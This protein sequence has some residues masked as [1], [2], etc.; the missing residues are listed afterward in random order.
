[1][2]RSGWMCNWHFLVLNV[3]E[4]NVVSVVLVVVISMGSDDMI[5]A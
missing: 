4:M 1:M 2:R 5:T 3:H